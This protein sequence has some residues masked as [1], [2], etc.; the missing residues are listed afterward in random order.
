MSINPTDKGL[1]TPQN[2]AVILIDFQPQMIF[3]VANVDRQTMLNNALILAKAAKTFG[4]P[5]ILT[6]VETKGFSGNTWPALLD[7]FPEHTPIERT[8]MN[9]WEDKNFVAAV[10][11]TGRKNLVIAALWTEACLTYPALHAIADGYS[12]YAVEDACGGTSMAA[13]D[14]AMRRIEQAGAVPMTA[15]QVLLEFQRD[16]ARKEHYDE[17]LAIVKEHAGAYGQG[18]EYAYTM[19]HG[20]PPSRQHP[21]LSQAA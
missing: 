18:V 21:A 7:L 9:S 12:V 6:A 4:V 16:W 14:A 20:A 13:H 2:C 10:K 1:L 3:G 8:S 15:I 19:V 17:V 5:V 11:K